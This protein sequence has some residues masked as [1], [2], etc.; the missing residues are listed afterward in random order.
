MAPIR[1]TSAR[2]TITLL[3]LHGQRVS[4]VSVSP[5][6]VHASTLTSCHLYPAKD[7][8]LEYW[9]S[10]LYFGVGKAALRYAPADD[11]D[12]EDV[13]MDRGQG[14]TREHT[15]MWLEYMKARDAVAV[16][17]DTWQMVRKE[18]PFSPPR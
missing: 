1:R 13:D 10:L 15:E 12:E 5:F 11:S 6:L 2:Y 7:I 14:W 8:A 18:D 4:V 16:S 17:K 9:K 3:I